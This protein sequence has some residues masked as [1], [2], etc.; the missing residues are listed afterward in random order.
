V[1]TFPLNTNITFLNLALRINPP[2]GDGLWYTI[3]SFQSD[4]SLTLAQP[5]LNAPNISS[6]TYTIGQ[7][8][9]LQEDFQDML[10][11]R[12]LMIY[13]STIV[14]DENR[15]KMY[16]EIYKEKLANLEEYLGTKT[17]NVDLEDEI[18]TKNPNIYIYS[19]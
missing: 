2:Y 12:A 7:L 1:G 11:Y 18:V 4:T 5:I 17:V 19:S 9:I 10:V 16:E 13:F 15:F 8:P 3:Q 6:A 14:K